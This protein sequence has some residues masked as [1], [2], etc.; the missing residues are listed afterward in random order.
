MKAVYLAARHLK[1]DRVARKCAQHLITRLSVD[2]CIEIRS[3]PGITRNKEFI[4][5]VDS[6]ITKEVINY[7]KNIYL[8]L[9][10]GVPICSLNMYAKIPYC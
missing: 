5:A 8:K 2:N 1:M 4:Q 9:Y 7:F 10:V 6:F 3:L